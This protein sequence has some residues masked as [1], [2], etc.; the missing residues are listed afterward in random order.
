MRILAYRCQR[1]LQIGFG[2]LARRD[3][4]SELDH[5]VRLAVEI[6]DRVVGRLD[7]HLAT[8]LGDALVLRR[9]EFTFAQF[10]PKLFVLGAVAIARLNKHAVVL[11]LDFRK[12]IAHRLQKI[13]VGGDDRSIEVKF[14][15]GLG[16]ADGIDLALIVRSLKFRRSDVR[17]ELHDLERLAVRVED[18]VVGRLNP[19]L[20]ATL[21][22]AFV[23][24]DLK[25][26]L[27]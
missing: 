8:A 19:N 3:V 26:A 1:G 25:F 22:D 15:H 16:F 10:A 24:R 23:L 14:D 9:L 5:L 11:A 21:R 27:V 20:A 7:P 4:G 12:R 6:H 18:R 13:I 2:R 17:G